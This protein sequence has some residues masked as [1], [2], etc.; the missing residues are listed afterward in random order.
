MT[1][2]TFK[3][4]E[5]VIQHKPDPPTPTLPPLPDTT[6]WP[7][8]KPVPCAAKSADDGK[9]RVTAK[10]PLPIQP[11]NDGYQITEFHD[12]NDFWNIGLGEMLI[13]LGQ[14]VIQGDQCDD[15]LSMVQVASL[16]RRY[17]LKWQGGST[18]AIKLE[19]TAKD[20]LDKHGDI[21]GGGVAVEYKTEFNED[22]RRD[23]LFLKFRR[24]YGDG[25]CH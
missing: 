21:K 14:K 17:R 7:Y 23:D 24:L 22:R 8:P 10:F 6:D 5:C 18:K 13:R 4:T 16:C 3:Q 12:S 20:Y 11:V 9:C 25:F 19:Q 1:T 15:W 2:I